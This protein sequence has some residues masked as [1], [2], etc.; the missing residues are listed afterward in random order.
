M[1]PHLH[2]SH[3]PSYVTPATLSPHQPMPP[4]DPL[5]SRTRRFRV[6]RTECGGGALTRSIQS[7]CS[8]DLKG[9]LL[10]GVLRRQQ[11][12]PHDVPPQRLRLQYLAPSPYLPSVTRFFFLPLHA[13]CDPTSPTHHSFL[14]HRPVPLTRPSFPPH[15]L[16]SHT[17]RFRVCR[18]ECGG[19]LTRSIQS[20]CSGDL[21]GS[22]LAGV[23]RR[24]RNPPHDVP[25][26]R[27]RSHFLAPSPNLPFRA[28]PFFLPLHA[29]CDPTSP[30]HHSFFLNSPRSHSMRSR[31]C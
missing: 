12:P 31:L 3:S 7:C 25:T 6:C 13:S 2:L 1:R 24:Q 20:C 27:L 19:V 22:L 23:L 21:K 17:M 5:R 16:R 15:L 30:T 4:T 8:G 14:P 18:T 11:N 26:Q 9:S 10:A 28:T 29:S